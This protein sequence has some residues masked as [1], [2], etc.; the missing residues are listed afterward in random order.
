MKNFE[1]WNPTR[2]VFGKGAVDNIGK[3]TAKFGSHALLVTTRGSIVR[4]GMFDKVKKLLSEAGV[5]STDLFGVEPNPKLTSVIE[6][7]KLCKENNVDV[8]VAL[9]GGS[10]IDCAKAIAFTA[11][12]DGDPWDFFI[13]KRTALKAIPLVVVLTIAGTGSEMN[14]NS[15]VTNVKTQQKLAVHYEMSYPET[16]I[17]DPNLHITVPKFLTACGMVDTIAH[18][19]EVYFDGSEGT[20]VQDRLAEGIVQTVFENETVLN[21]LKNISKRANLAWASTLALNGLNSAGR[22]GK[23]LYGHKIEHEIG[24]THDIIHAA[25]L[26]PIF[27]SILERKCYGNPKKF[28][29]FNE[30]VFGESKHIDPLDSGIEGIKKLHDKF[31]S[32]GMPMTLSQAGVTRDGLENVA[33]NSAKAIGD[34]LFSSEVIMEILNRNF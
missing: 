8:V 4:L 27:S 25:G 23:S 16:S 26:T 32:W 11:L 30:R 17:I 7:A 2:I 34:E 19:L 28:N 33:V 3:E 21:D 13:K 10:V 14:V 5:G 18:V 9:G 29:Q 20:D 12:D 6:G 24:G 1:F 22:E 31:R 15:V